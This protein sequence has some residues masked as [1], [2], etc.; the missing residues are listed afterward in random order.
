M[1]TI[2]IN[3]NSSV[4]L[5]CY[6]QVFKISIDSLSYNSF[7]FSGRYCINTRINQDFLVK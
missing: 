6:Y 4:P 5:L 7:F 3:Q 1:I 2:K